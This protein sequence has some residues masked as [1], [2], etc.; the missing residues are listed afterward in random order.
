MTTFTKWFLLTAVTGT[1]L[2]FAEM[3]GALSLI[4]ESDKSYLGLLIM[5]LFSIMTLR[6][7]QLAYHTDVATDK[8]KTELSKKAQLGWFTAEHFFSFGLLGTIIGLVLAT[9]GS[10][11]GSAPVSEIV[12]GLKTGLNTAFFTTICGIVFSLLLQLQ[13]LVLKDGLKK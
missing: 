13:L 1:V 4:I 2:F 3:K 10:L 7:G 6:V 11:D 5:I 8:Q 12:A 9:G